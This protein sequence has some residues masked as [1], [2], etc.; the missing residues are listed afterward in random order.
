M[1]EQLGT[2]ELIVGTRLPPLVMV[3]LAA[4]EML[5]LVPGF[6]TFT[7]TEPGDATA[8]AGMAA[9]NWVELTNVVAGPLSRSQPP[10]L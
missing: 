4:L 10:K 5:P 9:V 8:A 2:R 7:T 3:K 6:V 1:G